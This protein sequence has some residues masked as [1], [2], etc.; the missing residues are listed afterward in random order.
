MLI[1]STVVA[2]NA[3]VPGISST[4]ATGNSA[5][6]EFILS[7]ALETLQMWSEG[8]HLSDRLAQILQPHLARPAL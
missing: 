8:E 5:S 4:S 6:L 7:S 2:V 3:Q 1:K